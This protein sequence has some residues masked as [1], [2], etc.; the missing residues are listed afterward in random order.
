[1]RQEMANMM[2]VLNTYAALRKEQ[3]I[4]AV[5]QKGYNADQVRNF[6]D[7]NAIPEE[8]FNWVIKNMNI[9]DAQKI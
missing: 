9:Q 4:N 2:G 1:M 6:L 3:C 8:N 7:Q 5:V